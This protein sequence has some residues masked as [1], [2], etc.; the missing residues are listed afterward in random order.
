MGEGFVA[1]ARSMNELSI[2]MK[3]HLGLLKESEE[4]AERDRLNG[5]TE[6]ETILF[7]GT[8]L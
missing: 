3:R 8:T 4:E 6:E 1:M 7:D 2:T 5:F